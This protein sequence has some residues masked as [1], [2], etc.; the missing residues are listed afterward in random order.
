MLMVGKRR[1]KKGTWISLLL[2]CWSLGF[3]LAHIRP[4]PAATITPD[5]AGMTDPVSPAYRL[6]LVT[7]LHTCGSCHI[8]LPP[9][10][11]PTETWQSLL[12]DTQHYGTKIPPLLDPDLHLIWNYLQ[13][14]SRPTL[15]GE[16]EP[17]TLAD[18]RYFHAL[19]PRVHFTGPV[20]PNTCVSCH[21]GAAQ[22]DFRHLSTQ[23]Q[24]AP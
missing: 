6:G 16:I 18:S 3:G 8:A 20:T 15:A 17:Y 5:P 2:V 4:A 22:Y 24:N 21:P 13:E 7:Y 10:V 23:W 1:T 9:E 14:Y 19:H 12:L 11:F